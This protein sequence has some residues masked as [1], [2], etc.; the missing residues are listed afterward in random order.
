MQP[1]GVGVEIA[2]RN[3]RRGK[4][5]QRWERPV[6]TAGAAGNDWP[7]WEILFDQRPRQATLAVGLC[8][9]ATDK[10]PAA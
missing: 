4:P 6:T 5:V 7:I 9:A 8:A 10:K 1:L 2:S 3:R